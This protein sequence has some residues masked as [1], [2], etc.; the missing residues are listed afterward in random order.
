MAFLFTYLLFLSPLQMPAWAHQFLDILCASTT[1]WWLRAE[2]WGQW[3]SVPV[4]SV[5]PCSQLVA[6]GVLFAHLPCTSVTTHWCRH[7]SSSPCHVPVLTYGRTGKPVPTMVVSKH[8]HVVAWH[9]F[10]LACHSPR[11]PRGS[12][13]IP[14]YVPSMSHGG[15]GTQVCACLV[16]ALTQVE[17]AH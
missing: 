12:S 5:Y 17:P 10:S 14:V 15:M 1:T 13:G 7:A 6:W 16:P 3:S 2:T 8:H 9:Y 4:S 11:L